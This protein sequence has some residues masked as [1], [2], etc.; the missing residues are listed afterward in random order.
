VV[1]GGVWLGLTLTTLPP[2]QPAKAECPDHG[3]R[4]PGQAVEWRWRKGSGAEEG[5][6]SGHGSAPKK[7][8]GGQAR[9]RARGGGQDTTM[10]DQAR[11]TRSSEQEE[12]VTAVS[13]GVRSPW[14]PTPPLLDPCTT[15]PT[16]SFGHSE[17]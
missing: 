6:G 16:T 4:W 8:T 11:P 13:G 15:T 5:E 10:T 12:A 9:G 7:V 14:R 17:P 3:T 1:S 2:P